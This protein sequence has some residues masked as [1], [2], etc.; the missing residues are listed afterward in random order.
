MSLN[1]FI[2]QIWSEFQSCFQVFPSS[3]FIILM[4]AHALGISFNPVF[5]YFP[6]LTCKS[7]CCAKSYEVGF[8]PVFRYFPLLTPAPLA[9]LERLNEKAIRE[10]LFFRWKNEPIFRPFF[11][12]NRLNPLLKHCEKLCSRGKQHLPLAL[13]SLKEDSCSIAQYHIKT[14]EL[15]KCSARMSQT[16]VFR[17]LNSLFSSGEGS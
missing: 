14:K 2:P 10:R 13:F 12:H 9:A 6:L 16:A 1:Q 3:N 5:R 17:L 15:L 4:F 7:A 11:Q 8:N